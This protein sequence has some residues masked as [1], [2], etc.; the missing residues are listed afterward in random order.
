MN[1]ITHQVRTFW[2][3]LSHTS[4]IFFVLIVALLLTALVFHMGAVFG[5]RHFGFCER[6][7]IGRHDG[8]ARHFGAFGMRVRLPQEFIEGG[9]GAVGSV[10]SVSSSTM[11][12]TSRAGTPL[13]ITFT[14]ET[15]FQ[16]MKGTSQ[17]P[18]VGD[19]VVVIGEPSTT[20]NSINAR[21]I[22]VLPS[23]R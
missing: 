17:A 6:T 3:K 2:E 12:L 20:S 14:R 9:H 1:K 19:A 18:M 16:D 15:Q 22:K 7:F 10:T 4:R 5:A 21:I 13:T 8:G 23:P 11:T